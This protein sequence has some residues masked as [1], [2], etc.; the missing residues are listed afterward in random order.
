MPNLG[1]PKIDLTRFFSESSVHEINGRKVDSKE[2]INGVSMIS[3]KIDQ[4]NVDSVKHFTSEGLSK[5]DRL[6]YV[7]KIRDSLDA[8][9]FEM[10]TCNRVL[11]V[12]FGVDSNQLESTVLKIASIS[13]APFE[14]RNGLDVWRHLVKVCS[15]LDSF[16]IGEL[17][18]MSQFRGSVALHRQHG[19]LSDINSSFFDHVISANRI[20]R[21][22]F[23]FTQTTESMLNLATTALEEA[24]DAN[25]N[26][27]SVILGFGD[28]G[29]KAIE[30]LLELGQSNIV[31]ITR[32][33]SKA[34]ERNPELS[35]KVKLMTFAEWIDAKLE[36]N[37]VFST[38]RNN[39]ATFGKENPIPIDNHATI[40]DFSW[41]PSIDKEG[42]KENHVL[43]GMEHWIRV[44]HRLGLEWDYSSI[45]TQSEVLISEI[46]EKFMNALTDRSRSKFRAYMYK[47][48][49]KLSL[50]WESSEFVGKS[51]EQLGAFSR[52][53]ATWIC[54]QEGPFSSE[55]LT[56]MMMSTKRPFDQNL[57]LKV[58]N[59][60]NDTVNSINEMST[61]PGENS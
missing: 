1:N 15:G 51:G 29:S 43:Y 28:M 18:V 49:E 30:V 36:P 41:P 2:L 33:P 48:L 21:R 9:V 52:E 12:G 25:S 23:G 58:A 39:F 22:E 50:E 17:Q 27:S 11:F 6:S 47:T 32:S 5:E 54:N 38:I 13:S 44:A 31:V 7:R 56:E 35:S 61:F 3:M 60:V 19:L 16:I 4:S 20:I 34:I 37:L 40:M 14:H 10:S 45:I 24:V 55:D 26:N 53:I 8:D 57:L 42:V 46:Q 59:D